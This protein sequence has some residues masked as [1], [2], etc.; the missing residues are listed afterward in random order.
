MN[1]TAIPSLSESEN[2]LLQRLQTT[3]HKDPLVAEVLQ[4]GIWE[5]D[6][7]NATTRAINRL[8][9]ELQQ[10]IFSFARFG[11]LGGFEGG[12]DKVIKQMTA[13]LNREVQ[14]E[15]SQ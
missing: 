2:T 14:K 13:A 5:Q 9:A 7:E 4:A 8:E 12:M 1:R 10:P 15:A 3:E 11:L 6:L